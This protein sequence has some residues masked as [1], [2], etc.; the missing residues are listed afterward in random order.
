[1]NE[2]ALE[3]V[4]ALEKAL[5]YAFPEARI[6]LRALTHKSWANEQ[7]AVADGDN[8]RLE[9]LGDA[10]VGLCVSNR[11][12]ARCP[13]AQEGDLSRLRASLVNATA[14]AEVARGIG[15]GELLRLGRGEEQTGGRTKPSL[16]ADAFEAVIG[17]TYLAGGIE[18]AADLVDKHLLLGAELELDERD[19]DHKTRLQE[20]AQARFGITPRYRA[21]G[22][23]G[24]AHDKIF[25]AEIVVG[26]AVQAQ[27][28]GRTKK[29]AQQAAARRA[30]EVLENAA[31]EDAEKLTALD[32]RPV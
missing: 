20:I 18:A 2:E 11:L 23:R 5:G 10:V 7:R 9:F 1:M 12:M 15:L 28:E 14:L 13:A 31:E 26:D 24:P 6:A 16:L 4:R 19:R 17:A 27:G 3:R 22:E 21:V 25:V 30:L 29:A 8:E 32:R